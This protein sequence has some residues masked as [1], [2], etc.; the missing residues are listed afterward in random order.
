MVRVHP[1]APN[2]NTNMRLFDLYENIT[3]DEITLYNDSDCATL[4]YFLAKKL[5]AKIGMLETDGEWFNHA[6]VLLDE[7][8]GI[9]IK[10]KRPIATIRKEHGGDLF[11]VTPEELE[12]SVFI[13]HNDKKFITS[14]LIPRLL[15]NN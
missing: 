15:K 12:E 10:G 2:I 8:T 5:K 9:D 1:R 3:S 6:F 13:T 7:N 11:I 14:N 4:A